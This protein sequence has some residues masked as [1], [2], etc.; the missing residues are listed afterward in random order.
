MKKLY[1]VFGLIFGIVNLS[2]GNPSNTISIPISAVTKTIISSADYNTNNNEIATKFNSHTHNDISQ[3]GTITT[4]LWA[5][6]PISYAYLNVASSIATTDFTT[7]AKQY[8]VPTGGIIMWSGSIASVP[9]GW[10]LCDGT[11]GTPDLR[12]RFIVAA[13]ADVGGVAESTITG[14]A[15]KSS[16][17]GV[18]PAHTHTLATKQVSSTGAY[19]GNTDPGNAGDQ[20]LTTGSSGTGTKV[21]AVF[22]AL[23]YIQ[24]L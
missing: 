15:L 4:G 19:S 1:L 5:A 11:N 7:T 2:F 6:T 17:T 9:T 21:I 8:L 23:A 20:T 22:W 16:D 14:A 3:L 13:D 10:H 12:N 18:F 24:K